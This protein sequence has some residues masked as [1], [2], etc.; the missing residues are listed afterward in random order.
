[1]WSAFLQQ[2][3]AYPNKS[4]SFTGGYVHKAVEDA[5]ASSAMI[6]LTYQL[7]L[8]QHEYLNAVGANEAAIVMADGLKIGL[9]AS[10]FL[11]DIFKLFSPDAPEGLQIPQSWIDKGF[12]RSALEGLIGDLKQVFEGPLQVSVRECYEALMRGDWQVAEDSM[13]NIRQWQ[14]ETSLHLI[15][16]IITEKM[17]NFPGSQGFFKNQIL[18][19]F[20]KAYN[21]INDFTKWYDNQ[22]T[23]FTDEEKGVLS[24]I[25]KWWSLYNAYQEAVKK[26][27]QNLNELAKKADQCLKEH[28]QTLTYNAPPQ[29]PGMIILNRPPGVTGVGSFDP[30]EKYTV[31]AG[32]EGYITGDA[33]IEYVI[34]FENKA[35]ATAAAQQVTVTDDLDPN[36]DL[37][38]LEVGP[39]GFNEVEIDVPVGLQYFEKEGVIVA[40][41]PNPVKI[42]V[43]FNSS[44]RRI[45]W[46]IESVDA[47]TGG[48]PEDPLS[49]FLPPNDAEH[50]G[51]G[52]VSFRIRA[53]EN[54]PTGS[55]LLNKAN[56][57]FD[58]NEPI[59]T[60]EV[61]N[62]IDLDAPVS[63][64]EDLPAET[65]GRTVVIQPV[66][67]D[68]GGSGIGVHN[69]YV[70]DNG[71]PYQFWRST[72]EST[73]EFTGKCGHTYMFY[74]VATDLVGNVG[75]TP[76]APQAVTKIVGIP[77]DMNE[78]MIVELADAVL[79]M[80]VIVRKTS[81]DQDDN[82]LCGDATSDGKIGLGDM[83]YIL[84][85]VSGFRE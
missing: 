12:D 13:K 58:V 75:D 65:T 21:L 38:T 9:D 79:G 55:V 35:T 44:T 22:S 56:I 62:T 57:V 42:H 53:K 76:A 26:H 7:L 45:T 50:R 17:P 69:I 48:L 18:S 41:D 36:L 25:G 54:I 23:K 72:S 32:S 84:Q 14:G 5:E 20:K 29:P 77:G 10:L 81:A 68:E 15:E 39:I 33:T 46:L 67:S 27:N 83:I 49:G 82:V 61:T 40:T 73:V 60:P 64:I 4:C 66:G 8:N 6:D 85:H 19:K 37:T 31:G 43:Q 70:S 24:Q 74:N 63:G 1:M 16:R 28:S 78:D 47:T 52:Y 51:E 80:Q 59:L 34:M 11:I 71:G 2:V 30:N 3:P